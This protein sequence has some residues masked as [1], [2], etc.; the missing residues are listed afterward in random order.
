M[1]RHN[2]VLPNSHFHKDWQNRVKTWFDQAARKKRRRLNRVTKAK[3]IFPRPVEG[4]LRP[5]VRGQTIQY[6]RKLKLGRGFTLEEL[7]EAGINRRVAKTIGIAVD[8]RRRNRSDKS[9]K[10]NVQR[11][12]NYKSRLVVFPRKAKHPKAGDAPAAEVSKATQLRGPVLAIPKQV[13]KAKKQ[14]V[15]EVE[16][17]HSVYER[18]RKARAD[19]RLVG[20]RQK[21]AEKKAAA[22]ALEAAKANK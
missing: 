5:V 19:V 13:R 9:L 11:L 14:K 4:A 21:R 12:K 3:R 2:N 22:A 18:L 6:N 20:V 7:K 16:S 15:S 1:V 10:E 17:K 8:H